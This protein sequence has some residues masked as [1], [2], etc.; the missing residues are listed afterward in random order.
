MSDTNAA[1]EPGPESPKLYP[2]LT[3]GRWMP[4]E[5]AAIT[6]LDKYRLIPFATIN[7]ASEGQ[8]AHMVAAAEA[9]FRRGAPSPYERGAILERAATLLEAR[10]ADFIA[11]M[12][13]EAGFTAAARAA[14]C[15]ARSRRSSCRGRRRAVFAAR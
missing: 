15:A 10:S 6:V 8:A 4:G 1:I 2:L 7:A 5:G 9:A 14:R 13:A 11:T 12:Q 3:D